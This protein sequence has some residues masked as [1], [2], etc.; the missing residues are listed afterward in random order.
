[1]TRL[2]S[3]GRAMH[4]HIENALSNILPVNLAPGTHVIQQ[5]YPRQWEEVKVVPMLRVLLVS[6]TIT[7][8]IARAHHNTGN[9]KKKER[10]LVTPHRRWQYESILSKDTVE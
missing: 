6:T 1:M 5:P 10:E 7:G 8:T 9:L 2:V 4:V 3:E